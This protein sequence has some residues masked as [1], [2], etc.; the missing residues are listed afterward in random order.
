M[1]EWNEGLYELGRRLS[2]TYI[3]RPDLPE[4][5]ALLLLDHR[6]STVAVHGYQTL[7][8]LRDTRTPHT[9]V[10]LNLELGVPLSLTV[11]PKNAV[12]KLFQGKREWDTP[13]LEQKFRIE[14]SQEETAR[15]L[16]R[17]P[18][19]RDGL[20]SCPQTQLRLV[21][22]TG[23]WQGE[24]THMLQVHTAC[25]PSDSSWTKTSLFEE[26][27]RPV[28]LVERMVELAKA[29]HDAVLEYRL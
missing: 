11:R 15:R 29:T 4:M 14:A 25:I 18:A 21:P 16:L 12:Q 28:A 3:G 10:T 19:L 9:C 6:G 23:G 7:G 22:D 26:G 13:E 17:F 20:L 5:S 1:G 8:P 2:G 24:G 27:I